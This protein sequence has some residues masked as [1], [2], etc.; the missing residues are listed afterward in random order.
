MLSPICYDEF[1][2]IQTPIRQEGLPD[3]VVTASLLAG[4]LLGA[5]LAAVVMGPRVR[6]LLDELTVARRERDRL[7]TELLAR[8]SETSQA[9]FEALRAQQEL[10][11]LKRRAAA[12]AAERDEARLAEAEADSAHRQILAERDRL[13]GELALLRRRKASS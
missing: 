3:V 5:L 9:R 13:I 2:T 8:R 4:A 10:L 11:A 6:L 1:Y 7:Q 12:A